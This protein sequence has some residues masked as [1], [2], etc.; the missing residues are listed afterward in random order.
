MAGSCWLVV[1]LR[2]MDGLGLLLC[3]FCEHIAW[4]LFSKLLEKFHFR[5]TIFSP[6]FVLRFFHCRLC[7]L[8]SGF[9][10]LQGGLLSL[11]CISNT[12]GPISPAFVRKSLVAGAWES[13]IYY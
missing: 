10:G 8:I 11:F 6:V 12:F 13:A 9:F 5:F 1:A 2:N 4:I 7:L 3:V